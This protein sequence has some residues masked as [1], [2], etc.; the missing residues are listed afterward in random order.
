MAVSKYPW[1]QHDSID[2]VVQKATVF[3]PGGYSETEGSDSFD[4]ERRE[5]I[6][7]PRSRFDSGLDAE[8]ELDYHSGPRKAQASQDTETSPA[9]RVPS[10]SALARIE[11]QPR[12]SGALPEASPVEHS[13]GTDRAPSRTDSAATAGPRKLQLSSSQRRLLVLARLL[14]HR[15]TARLVLLDEPFAGMEQNEVTPLHSMLK[16]QL[17]H[18]ALMTVTHRLLPVIHFFS[19][20]LVFHEGR[21]SEVPPAAKRMSFPARGVSSWCD[22][23]CLSHEVS[24]L[25]R[26]WLKNS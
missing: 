13:P 2:S 19:R 25:K 3:F 4:E 15:H 20:I 24:C 11:E 8:V 6:Y 9:P 26:L 23:L 12:P 14:L 21:C 7:G 10:T 1:W 5:E 22:V 18:A 17:K 16:I